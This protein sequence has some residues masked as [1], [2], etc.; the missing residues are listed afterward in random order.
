MNIDGTI[1]YI[2]LLTPDFFENLFTR[3]NIHPSRSQQIEQL[4]LDVSKIFLNGTHTHTAPS[5][6]GALGTSA[7]PN[8]VPLLRMR[9]AEALVAAEANLKPARVGWASRA[10]PGGG[11]TT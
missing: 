8:Y 4:K 2:D 10:A 6:F 3:E 7:D 9:I 1:G 5:S 11:P